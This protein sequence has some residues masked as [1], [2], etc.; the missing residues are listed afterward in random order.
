MIENLYYK[1]SIYRFRSPLTYTTDQHE[2]HMNINSVSS[3]KKTKK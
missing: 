2:M 1:K 3:D